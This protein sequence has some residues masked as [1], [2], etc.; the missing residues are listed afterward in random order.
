MKLC[1]RYCSVGRAGRWLGGPR[2]AGKWVFG[3]AP[4]GFRVGVGAVGRCIL[5]APSRATLALAS[6]PFRSRASMRTVAS[7]APSGASR[8]R[9]RVI[10]IPAPEEPQQAGTHLVLD[11]G[12]ARTGADP[13]HFMAMVRAGRAACGHRAPPQRRRR[14]ATR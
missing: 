3:L 12:D 13:P 2:S 5:G 1:K 6:G 7:S 8:R 11:R 4:V 10:T 14:L 9:H